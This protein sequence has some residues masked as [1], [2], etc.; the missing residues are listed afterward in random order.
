MTD[1][2][3][4]SGIE[5]LARHG[6][7]EQERANPQRFLVDVTLF[8]DHRAAG[9]SDEI[10][11]TVDY[12]ETAS[13]IHDLVAGESH[14]LLERLASRLAAMLI[15][16]DRVSRVVVTVH[17]PEAPIPVPFGDVSVTVDRSR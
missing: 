14:Q 1:R 10:N 5:I 8:T 17:K 11:D 6:L 13:K 3:D 2:I 15:E 4:I 7:F 9:D 12:G 16:D